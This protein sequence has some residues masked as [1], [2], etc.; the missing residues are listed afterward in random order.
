MS[1]RPNR[2]GDERHLMDH[3]AAD[4][5]HVAAEPIQLGDDD[6]SP[7]LPGRLDSRCQLGPSIERVSTFAGLDLHELGCDG[8]AL[9]PGEPGDRLSLSLQ[10]ET[11][12]TLPGSRHPDVADDRFSRAKAL[13]PIFRE[14]ADL[15]TNAAAAELNRRGIATPQGGQRHAL[16]VIRLRQRLA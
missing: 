15:S 10:T 13:R 7:D 6:L 1:T 9:F 14:L 5:V 3:Q 4:E 12:A 16:T 8:V 11:A 2:A